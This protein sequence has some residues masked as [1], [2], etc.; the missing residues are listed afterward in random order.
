[1]AHARKLTALLHKEISMRLNY[2]Y[3]AVLVGSMGVV[4]CEK[5]QPAPAT[6]TATPTAASQTPAAPKAGEPA[7][8]TPATPATPAAPAGTEATIPPPPAAAAAVAPAATQAAA[9]TDAE[10]QK[11]LDE[12]MAYIKDNKLDLADKTLTKLEGMKS[13]LS[14][15]LQSGVDKARTMLDAAKAGG[16]IKLPSLAK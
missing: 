13:S 5:S 8:T 16:G 14:P 15:T 3:A 12:A 6:P 9:T 10:A 4:G 2:L 7:M 11:M 1:M